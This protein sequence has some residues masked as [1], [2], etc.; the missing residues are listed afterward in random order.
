MR[1][2]DK[3]R[4]AWSEINSAGRRRSNEETVGGKQDR[5]NLFLQRNL[6]Q[7]CECAV[8]RGMSPNKI[9]PA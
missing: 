6:F 2:P 5:L 7:E 1:V 9:G 8:R 4:A 3:L